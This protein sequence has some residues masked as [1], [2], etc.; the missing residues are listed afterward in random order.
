VQRH[1]LHRKGVTK[2]ESS[3]ESD[4]AWEMRGTQKRW[5]SVCAGLFA[6][7]TVAAGA[8]SDKAV[9]VEAEVKQSRNNAKASDGLEKTELK[10]KVEPAA[11]VKVDDKNSAAKTVAKASAIDVLAKRAI[12]DGFK[13]M[14]LQNDLWVALYRLD[15][16]HLMTFPDSKSVPPGLNIETHDG[17]KWVMAFTDIDRLQEYA[18]SRKQL[19]SDGTMLGMSVPP[20]TSF[21]FFESLV[22]IEGVRFNQGDNGWFAPTANLRG[23]HSYLIKGGQLP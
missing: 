21:P 19:N 2:G 3:Y 22:G 5:Q 15:K 7:T 11:E 1:R 13:D 14:A 20:A 12:D 23:I 18:K 8:C 6:L 16:W 17:K 4:Y 10:E 9:E